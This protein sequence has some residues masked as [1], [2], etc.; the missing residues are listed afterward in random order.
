MRGAATGRILAARVEAVKQG[1]R[2]TMS[3]VAHR[4]DESVDAEGVT[5]GGKCQEVFVVVGF[6]LEGVAEIGV[7]GHQ[8]P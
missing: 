2:Q 5:H 7:V 4:V 6:A 3:L 1:H 8:P